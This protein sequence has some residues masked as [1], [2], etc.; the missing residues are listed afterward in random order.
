[1]TD[2]EKEEYQTKRAE[3]NLRKLREFDKYMKEAP[4][5]VFNTNVFKNVK[6]AMPEEE[7]KKDEELVEE[8][9]KFLKEQAIPKLIKDLQSVEGVP[10]DS[11]S[12]EGVF[13]SHGINMRYLGYVAKELKDKELNH[14]KILL[15]R[16]V[17]FRSAKHLIN[18]HIRDSSDTYLSSV[19]SHLFN[20][21]L[22]PFPLI[23]L[24]NEG[25][26]TYEDQTIQSLLKPIQQQSPE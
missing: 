13:H 24:L 14:L 1:M 11:E 15:E 23:N 10:T 18:E 17:V 6:F 2:K 21:L 22:A 26:I 3:E 25:K 8:L 16:E 20:I 4:K 9:A 5:F 12:L 7:V 19:I